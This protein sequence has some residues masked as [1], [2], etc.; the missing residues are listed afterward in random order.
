MTSLTVTDDTSLTLVFTAA[1]GLTIESTTGYWSAGGT[2]TLDVT[3][4]FSLDEF[5]NG[6][7]TDGASDAP[8][9]IVAPQLTIVKSS[10]VISDPINGGTDP[11]RIP[12]AVVEY[13]VI[14]TNNGDGSPDEDTVV[15]TDPIDSG[16][17]AFD[18][19]TGVTFTDG[20]TSSALSLGT[21]AYSST[22]A[23][24]P[25]VYDYTPVPDGDGYDGVVTSVQISTTGTLANGGAPA[26]SFTVKFRVKVE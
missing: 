11:L 9:T 4:G 15:V 18:V 7:T 5:G 24:G 19:T 23:P 12:G 3:A 26:P 17:L 13:S 20:T 10:S 16:K 6:A 14:V 8:L 25:Y 1:K 2:D 21:V 22:A